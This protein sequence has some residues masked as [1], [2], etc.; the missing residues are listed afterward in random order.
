MMVISDD[1]DGDLDGPKDC[2]KVLR[3]PRTEHNIYIYIIIIV[4]DNYIIYIYIHIHMYIYKCI[5]SNA[6]LILIIKQ[7]HY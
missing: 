5:K 4:Y 1:D 7:T 2:L 6:T 3:R